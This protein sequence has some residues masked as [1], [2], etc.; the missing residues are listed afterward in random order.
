MPQNKPTDDGGV[1]KKVEAA[2]KVLDRAWKSNVSGKRP[3]ETP[4]PIAVKPTEPKPLAP[5]AGLLGEAESAGEGIK[6]MAEQAK[7]IP[8]MHKGGKVEEDGPKDLQKGEIV[9]PKDKKKAKEIVAMAKLGNK[10]GIMSSAAQEE[11][12][13]KDESKSE[14]KHETKKEEKSEGKHKDGKKSSVKHHFHK[15]EIEHHKNGSHTVRHIPH[16][17]KMGEDGKMGEQEPDV[18]YAAND[19]QALHGGLDANLGEGGGAAPAA[20]AEPGPAL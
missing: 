4:A 14:E 18:S 10:A 19:M 3:P 7:D 6:M 9:L 16:P 5:S 12:L 11:E 15:T 2:K 13:E 1:T 17:P 20:P 8:Q